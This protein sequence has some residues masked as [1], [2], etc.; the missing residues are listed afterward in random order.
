MLRSG[1]Y[2]PA[3]D[4][5][6]L[7]ENSELWL[8]PGII[9]KAG[10]VILASAPK[11]GK[12]CFATALA[13]AV[14]SGQDFLGQPVC[15][16]PVLWCSHEETPA[17]R[18]LLHKGLAIE[19]P[20]LIAYPSELSPLPARLPKVDRYGRRDLRDESP[21][22]VFEHAVN[23][24]AKLIVID[25]LHAAVEGASLADNSVARAVMSLLR[26]WSAH[27]NIAVLALHHL[28]K[29]STRGHQPERF[30]DSA[31]ILAASSCHFFMD[32]TDD[33]ATR[34]RFTL[35]GKGRH[36]APVARLEIV[37]EGVLDYRLAQ[38]DEKWVKPRR[39]SSTE[40]IK[41]CLEQGW[42]LTSL[43]IASKLDMKPGVVRNALAELTKTGSVVAAKRPKENLRYAIGPQEENVA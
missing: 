14:A 38:K 6:S 18:I 15:Q 8:V 36:P 19:D 41:L 34:T 31:Q 9:P 26:V 28:T 30:A 27:F 32:R 29:S 16:A 43:E 39:L 37:S 42:V 24:G 1:P 2:R 40:R 5:Q 7:I 12:T 22:E 3:A 13:R 35:I 11:T 23:V 17:E 4:L 21:P 20:F 10:L 33:S 25:C